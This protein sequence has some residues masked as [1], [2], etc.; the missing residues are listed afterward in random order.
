MQEINSKVGA[1]GFRPGVSTRTVLVYDG[2]LAP[3]IRTD[4]L[5]D[6]AIPAERL[7]ND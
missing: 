2:K 4:H 7:F 3:S 6:F 1:V 5:L